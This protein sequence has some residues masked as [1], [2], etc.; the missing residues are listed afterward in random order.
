VNSLIRASIDLA[1]PMDMCT[2]NRDRPELLAGNPVRVGGDQ[3]F[4]K[5]DG[6]FDSLDDFLQ[7][8]PDWISEEHSETVTF[9]FYVERTPIHFHL[10]LYDVR[11]ERRLGDYCVVIQFVPPSYFNERIKLP[12]DHKPYAVIGGLRRG[13]EFV[14]ITGIKFFKDPEHVSYRA[15]C[16]AWLQAIDF[17]RC[18]RMEPLQPVLTELAGIDAERKESLPIRKVATGQ[19][20]RDKIQSG[21]RIVNTIADGQPPFDGAGLLTDTELE[22]IFR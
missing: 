22:E 11:W 6:V 1:N 5:T 10:G 7:N 13:Q 19:A 12:I 16:V 2:M 17:R 14:F 8:H 21:S 4:E 18:V 9:D 15:R 20:P 3:S